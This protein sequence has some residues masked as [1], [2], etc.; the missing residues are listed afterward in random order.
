M[1]LAGAA[2]SV[3]TVQGWI[4]PSSLGVTDAHNH[5][6]IEPPPGVQPTA[7]RLDEPVRIAKELRDYRAA[8][9]GALVDCQPGGCGRDG[10]R[11]LELSEAS[12]IHVIACTGFHRQLYYPPEAWIFQASAGKA[13]EFFLSELEGSLAETAGSDRQVRAG[14]IKIACEARL[15][16][17][18]QA[19]L[20]AAAQASLE[21]G[22]ALEVHTEQGQAAGEILQFFLERG[23]PTTRL[24]LCH[25]DKRPDLGLHQELARAGV[26][27]EYDTF[28]R[29]KYDPEHNLWPLLTQMVNQGWASQIALGTDMA[30]PGMWSRLGGGPGL[31]GFAGAIRERLASFASQEDV[32]SLAG[33]NI[34]RRLARPVSEPI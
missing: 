32:E 23:V 33:G 1:N 28:Y 24:V 8:G 15:A 17:T 7:P 16:D 14:A 27:L 9:G 30:D 11:L 26:L 13:F 12:G 20:E 4:D 18:P 6:W 19:L 2:G 31:A 21:T 5:L 29:P 34:A 25:L 22:A 3:M 10:N